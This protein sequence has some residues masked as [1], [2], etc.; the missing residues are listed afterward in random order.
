MIISEVFKWISIFAFLSMFFSYIGVYSIYKK[1]NWIQSFKDYLLCFAAGILIATP[2]LVAFPHSFEKN[3][4][5]SV[6]AVLGFVFMFFSDKVIY[7]LT[8]SKEK[9][10]GLIGVIAI[11]FHSFIDGVIYTITFNASL[12]IGFLSACGLVAHEFAEGIISY[13]FLIA[14]GYS[15]KK[16]FLYSFI[17]AG[18]TTPFGAFIVYPIISS[19]N[20]EI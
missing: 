19:L 17:I 20:E 6:F 3:P 7:N 2:F 4:D 14:G 5:T 11:G 18:L 15:P 9:A 16:A 12:V 13:T 10:F 1:N 8:K